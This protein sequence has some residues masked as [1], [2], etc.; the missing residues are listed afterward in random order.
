MPGIKRL[1]ESGIEVVYSG[2]SEREV[3]YCQRCLGHNIRSKLGNRVY[4]L[5][6]DETGHTSNIPPDYDLW[7]QCHLCGSI[8]GRH[9]AKQEAELSTLIGPRDSAYTIKG[10]VLGVESRKFDT[11]SPFLNISASSKNMNLGLV[12]DLKESKWLEG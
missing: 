5:M 12:S 8:Y 4:N 3:A 9:E 6:P 7:R 11:C 10:L 1:T 2:K